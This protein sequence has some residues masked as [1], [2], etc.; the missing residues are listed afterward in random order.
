MKKNTKPPKKKD[1]IDVPFSVDLP[2]FNIDP[3]FDTLDKAEA[4]SIN[5]DIIASLAEIGSSFDLFGEDGC[6]IANLFEAIL[7]L[8]KD[9]KVRT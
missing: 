3:I 1:F 7:R 4:A 2:R 9:E 8:A 5:L 6:K